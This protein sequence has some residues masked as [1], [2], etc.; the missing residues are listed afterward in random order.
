MGSTAGATPELDKD[1]MNQQ[2][3]S[4]TVIPQFQ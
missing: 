1:W 2:Q 4:L 3:E